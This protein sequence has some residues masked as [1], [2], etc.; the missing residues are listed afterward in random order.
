MLA[1]F[2][3]PVADRYFPE[4][5]TTDGHEVERLHYD[6]NALTRLGSCV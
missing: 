6:E 5:S 3:S 4:D 1:V 2:R